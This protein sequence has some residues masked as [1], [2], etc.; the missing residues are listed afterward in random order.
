MTKKKTRGT[1]KLKKA[2][3]GSSSLIKKQKNI[4]SFNSIKNTLPKIGTI[5][6]YLNKAYDQK[7][8][9]LVKK[10]SKKLRDDQEKL[11]KIYHQI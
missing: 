2:K 5:Y 7:K 8:D 4:N 3:V 1:R 6:D 9:S 11:K 10:G